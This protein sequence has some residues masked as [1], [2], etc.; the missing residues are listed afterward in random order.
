MQMIKMIKFIIVIGA[1]AL[2]I[3]NQ[4]IKYIFIGAMLIFVLEVFLYC[5]KRRSA[6]L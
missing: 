6:Q 1:L 3:I 4:D 5:E 2:G